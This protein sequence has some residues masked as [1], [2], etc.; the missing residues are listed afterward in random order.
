MKFTVKGLMLLI[1]LS[2]GVFLHAGT[3]TVGTYDVGN[4]YP[5][6][7]NDSGTNTGPAIDYQQVYSHTAFPGT[8]T[9]T[10]IQFAYAAQFGGTSTVLPGDY[11]FWLGTSANPFNALSS[12]QVANRSA[13]WTLV[14]SLTNPVVDCNPTCTFNLPTSFTYNPANGDLLFEVIATNQ[15]I[16][17]NGSG[18]GYNEADDTGALMSRTWCLANQNCANAIVDSVGLVTTFSTGAPIPEPGTLVMLG[19]GVVGL[20]GLL[21]RKI[22]P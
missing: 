1:V 10:D 8:I 13:D 7:C 3:V 4:C 12:N 22:S 21:R 20:A 17:S 16:F 19:S 9:I 11:G 14:D 18:N 15:M 2:V 6:L 5:F